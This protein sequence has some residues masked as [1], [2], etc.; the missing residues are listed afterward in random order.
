MIPRE[1]RDR[2]NGGEKWGWGQH[3]LPF[4]PHDLRQV[5]RFGSGQ[6]AN[7]LTQATGPASAVALWQWGKPEGRLSGKVWRK[8][9]LFSRRI[10]LGLITVRTACWDGLCS[11]G[12]KRADFVV[13]KLEELVSFTVPAR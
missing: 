10:I 11:N 6:A 2:R 13:L 3:V 7:G 8:D 5:P 12:S 4:G 9:G 1:A